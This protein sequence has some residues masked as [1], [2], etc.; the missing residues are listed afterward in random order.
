MAIKIKKLPANHAQEQNPLQQPSLPLRIDR[1][2]VVD[3]IGM[4]VLSDGTPYLNQAGLA[5]L[6]DISQ[7]QLSEINDDWEKESKPRTRKIK[8][9]LRAQDYCWNAP[10]ISVEHNGSEHLAYPDAVCLS[11]LE[12]YAWHAGRYCKKEAQEKFSLL[13][14]KGFREFIYSGVG[15]QPKGK[16]PEIWT[17][18]HDRLSLINNNVPE[19]YFCIFKEMA[20]LVIK[21]IT[22]GANVGSSFVPDISVGKAW[23][24]HWQSQMLAKKYGE[25]STYMHMYPDYFPQAKSNPQHPYCYPDA[26]LGEFRRWMREE[27]LPIKFSAYL[28]RQFSQG[29]LPPSFVSIAIDASTSPLRN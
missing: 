23:S 3:G 26:A 22:H 29:K 13:A 17:Q 15:Y 5:N 19:G 18:F 14:R 11:I 2:E 20:D 1:E 6:C 16:V 21:L 24:E 28:Q 7:S 9:I 10:Y 12:Y 4:G 27:Y 8:D 25:R